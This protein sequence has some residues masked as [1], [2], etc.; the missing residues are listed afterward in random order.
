MYNLNFGGKLKKNLEA[1]VSV[2][3][4]KLSVRVPPTSGRLQIIYDDGVFCSY[5]FAGI[6]K[7]RDGYATSVGFD[8]SNAPVLTL[9][10]TSGAGKVNVVYR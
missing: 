6:V 4:G 9:R 1:N 5:N 3:L 7:K 8:Q 2:G 10:I